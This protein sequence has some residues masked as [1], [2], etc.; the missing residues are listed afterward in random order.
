MPVAHF[1]MQITLS[2]QQAQFTRVVWLKL[3]LVYKLSSGIGLLRVCE[4]PFVL[5]LS[6]F[7]FYSTWTCQM[8]TFNCF[9]SFPYSQAYLAETFY[10]FSLSLLT[11]QWIPALYFLWAAMRKMNT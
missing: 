7:N 1:V 8:P 11:M 4:L 3:A 2:F 5:I 10:S 9:F 6:S